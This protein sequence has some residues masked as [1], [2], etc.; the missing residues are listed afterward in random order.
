MS[1]IA[2]EVPNA[3]P[4]LCVP[5]KATAEAMSVC[6][7]TVDTL[8]ASGELPCIRI[9]RSVRVRLSDIEKYLTRHVTG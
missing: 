5:R 4:L 2:M 9:G 6:V 8:I 1:A 7:R 3:V